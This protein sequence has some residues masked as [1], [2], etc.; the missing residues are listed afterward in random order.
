MNRLL[1][2]LLDHTGKSSSMRVIVFL[3]VC[4]QMLVW[5]KVSWTKNEIQPVST[6]QIMLLLGPLGIQ[7]TQKK[8]AEKSEKT[9]VDTGP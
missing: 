5:A 4:T 1:P 8:I 3:V 9:T 6:E 7:L 2:F